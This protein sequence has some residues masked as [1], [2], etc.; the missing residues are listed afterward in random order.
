MA[1]TAVSYNPGS[2]SW[3]VTATDSEATALD[4]LAEGS[5]REI[6][7]GLYAVK[8]ATGLYEVGPA[9]AAA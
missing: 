2:S 9:T 6:R 8:L 4:A 5:G 3:K 1:V 7:K